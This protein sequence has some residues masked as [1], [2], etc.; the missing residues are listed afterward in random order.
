LGR[1]FG[2]NP[3]DGWFAI[4]LFISFFTIAML[5][6]TRRIFSTRVIFAPGAISGLRS[7]LPRGLG[8]F[9]LGSN[10]LGVFG[11]IF[12]AR[13]VVFIDFSSLGLDR[14]VRL[15]SWAEG[16]NGCGGW[17]HAGSSHQDDMLSFNDP[18]VSFTN[19][20]DR[21]TQWNILVKTGF[22]ID[23]NFQ[24]INDGATRFSE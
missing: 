19:D 15:Q 13:S 20:L 8:R 6:A 1:F 3:Q 5:T 16:G 14:V 12:L 23:S 21:G 11:G 22:F 17:S 18:V 10:R 4:Q 7:A 24:P 2:I 9:L